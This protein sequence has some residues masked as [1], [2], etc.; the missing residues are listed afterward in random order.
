MRLF[1]ATL[2]T[3]TNTFSPLPTSLDAYREGVF[4]RPGEHP[5]DTPLMCT[6]P[7]FVARRRAAAEGF[8]LVEGSCFAASPA[9]TTNRTDFEFRFEIRKPLRDRIFEVKDALL[10][11]FEGC[12]RGD[13]FRERS[14]TEDRLF[15]HRLLRFT[16]RE[17]MGLP[18]ND[19]SVFRDDHDRSDDPLFSNCV[20]NHCVQSLVQ[21]FRCFCVRH[22]LRPHDHE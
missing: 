7:L 2:A 14:E 9:G 16:I 6:A 8:T 1:S 10:H 5:D 18:V 13:G 19:F 20:F 17:S 4:L 12:D 11:E 15:L 22:W 3:E 21:V